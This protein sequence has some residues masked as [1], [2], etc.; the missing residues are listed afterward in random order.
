MRT[1]LVV[2]T[3]IAV[4]TAGVAFADLNWCGESAMNI[5]NQTTG[6][7]AWYNG[8]ATW[9]AGGDWDSL[10]D[11]GTIN[12]GDALYL[13]GELQSYD[14]SGD[15]GS[16]FYRIDSGSYTEIS[17]PW[18]EQTGNNDK[19]QA[20]YSTDIASGLSAGTYTVDIYFSATDNDVGP[21]TVYDNNGG[22]DYVGATFTVAAIPEPGTLTLLGLGLAGGFALLRRRKA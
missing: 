15:S 6:A 19:W 18:L 5:S 9:A 21:T 2:A 3:C 13:G 22:G 20:M 4:L 17:L 10:L 11:L 16:M 1:K 14:M 8:S 12:L 7:V